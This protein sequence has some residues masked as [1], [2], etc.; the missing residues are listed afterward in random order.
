MAPRTST[1]TMVKHKTTPKVSDGL[2]EKI[3]D[4]VSQLIALQLQTP[5]NIPDSDDDLDVADKISDKNQKNT[6]CKFKTQYRTI[7]SFKT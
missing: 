7:E 1:K 5:P 2:F 4:N 3:T 6:D